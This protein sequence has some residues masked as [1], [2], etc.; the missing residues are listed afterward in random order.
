VVMSSEVVAVVSF[1]FL[2][3]VYLSSGSSFLSCLHSVCHTIIHRIHRF[4]MFVMCYIILSSIHGFSPL[5]LVTS[6]GCKHAARS[7]SNSRVNFVW[8]WM[9]ICDVQDL[10]CSHIH[11]VN[12]F[13]CSLGLRTSWIIAVH[14]SPA[15]ISPSPRAK[16]VSFRRVYARSCH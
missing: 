13:F 7:R 8:K 12:I 10:N 4:P 14:I 1:S 6:S 16:R 5:L 9:Q 3:L 15:M 2:V 11:K